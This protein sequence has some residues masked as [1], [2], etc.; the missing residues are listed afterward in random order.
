MIKTVKIDKYGRFRVPK[1]MR[2]EL[3]LEP[4]QRFEVHVINGGLKLHPIAKKSED[5]EPEQ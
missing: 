1:A 2:E 4:R 3:S 5:L